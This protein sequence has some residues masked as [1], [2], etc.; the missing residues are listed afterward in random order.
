MLRP[1]STFSFLFFV[2]YFVTIFYTQT[3]LLWQK[4]K[5]FI[6]TDILYIICSFSVVKQKIKLLLRL[7]LQRLHWKIRENDTLTESFS[8]FSNNW[9]NA[10]EQI[11][12]KKNFRLNFSKYFECFFLLFCIYLFASVCVNAFACLKIKFH[13][14]V[15]GFGINH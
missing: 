13:C 15:F 6:F 5:L 4:K 1:R 11:S 7:N 3:K 12:F 8:P 10:F 9:L 2:F 14:S